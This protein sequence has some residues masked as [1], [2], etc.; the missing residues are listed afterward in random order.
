MVCP[1]CKSDQVIAV[2]DQHFCINCGQMVPEEKTSTKGPKVAVQPNGLPEGVKILPVDGHTPAV[3][4]VVEATPSTPSPA[5]LDITPRVSAPRKSVP[6]TQTANPE[7][8]PASTP[9]IIHSRGRL[10]ATPDTPKPE[11]KRKPGRPKAGRLDIPR[12]IA[13]VAPSQNL[14]EAPAISAMTTPVKVS[15]PQPQITIATNAATPTPGPTKARRMSDI[16][17]RRAPNPAEPAEAITQTPPPANAS[18]ASAPEAPSK[19]A[20]APKRAKAH[21]HKVG[22]PPIHYG[23]VISFSLRA[24]ARLRLVALAAL[25]ALSIGGASAYGVWVI[26]NDGMGGLADSLIQGGPRVAAE[27][28][29]LFLIYYI[30][31]SLGQTAITFGIAREADGRPITM[32]RQFGV[33]VNTFWRRIGLDGIFGSLE[34]V[35][36]GLGVVLFYTGG[37]SWSVPSNVQMGAIFAA[38]LLLLYLL[39]ALLISR[40][41]A[42]VNLALTT[43]KPFTAAKFGWKLF[44]HRIELIGPRFAALLMEGALAIPLVALAV[45]FVMEAPSS[46]YIAVAIGAGLLAW[47]AGALVGVGTAAWWTMLYRQL[48]MVDHPDRIVTLLSSRQPEDAS[49][50]PLSAIVAIST[51]LIA[52]TLLIP[53]L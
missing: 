11:K 52:L 2:Q 31:R 15:T 30:G 51:L 34:L 37:T 10:A 8:A 3:S 21:A 53:W 28:G 23:A 13:S 44:S 22:V 5:S 45:A 4:S 26:L 36:L 12:S 6:S 46:W 24:R 35:V 1:N 42:G 47:L 32:S 41:L 9:K 25:G 17:P 49:R 40:G 27:A 16:S 48:V 39:S 29:L 19:P 33:A 14:P 50:G 18:P 20:K 43:H 7:P 38:Y